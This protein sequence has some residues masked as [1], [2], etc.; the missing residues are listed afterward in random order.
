[1]SLGTY[2]TLVSPS[3]LAAHVNDGSWRIFDCRFSLNDTERG[4]RDYLVSH[5]PGAQYAHLDQ[6]LSAPKGANTGR[7]PLPAPDVFAAWLGRHG[8]EDGVQV[9]AYDDGNGA[10]A[11]RMWWMLRWLG[12]DAVAVLDGGLHAWR[13]ANIPVSVEFPQPR[14][15]RF[16]PRLRSELSVSSADVKAMV[17]GGRGVLIDARSAERF[18][19][20]QEPI[21]PVA[22]H[23]PGALNVPFPV[24]LDAN[25]RFRSADELRA[26]YRELIGEHRPSDVVHMCG[27]GVTACHN[28]LAMEFAGLSGSRLYVGSWSEWITDP[29]RPISTGA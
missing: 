5:I 14:E 3:E 8:I 11:A 29:H 2:R 23:V 26:R 13:L 17:A 1:M 4:R 21:D 16:T 10:I 18:R 25:G 6:D 15:A 19:G 24:N 22:G 20:E 28:L 7:H 12:H 9:V 27:S